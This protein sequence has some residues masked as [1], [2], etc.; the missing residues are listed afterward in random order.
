M[1][2][3]TPG[4]RWGTR[5]LNGEF[6]SAPTSFD[7]ARATA[8]DDYVADALMFDTLVHNDEDATYVGG[9]ATDWEAKCASEYVFTIRDD[10][11]CADGT[12]ITASVVA[13]SLNYLADPSA[14]NHV[15]AALVFG[16]A[17]RRSPPTTPPP[18]SPSRPRRPTS[19]WWPA[20]RSRSRGSSARPV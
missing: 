16:P 18:R 3:K 5:T 9:L 4:R 10:A 15:A 17:S 1:G 13:D 6:V 14:G 11:T 7:P 8:R 19:T 2:A 12:K 20:S